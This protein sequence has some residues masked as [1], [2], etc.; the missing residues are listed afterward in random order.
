MSVGFQ[1][2][3]SV[4]IISDVTFEW[5]F[6]SGKQAYGGTQL[7]LCGKAA[8]GYAVEAGR[9]RRLADPGRA[10]CD[11]M[12][13]IITHRMFFVDLRIQEPVSFKNLYREKTRTALTDVKI[14]ADAIAPI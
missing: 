4:V 10:G 14:S 5:E 3:S 11:T 7:S 8:R 6:G 13:A 1:S 2:A 9:N 12:Q